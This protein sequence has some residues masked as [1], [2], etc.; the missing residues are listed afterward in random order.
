MAWPED[1][2]RHRE[3]TEALRAWA[4]KIDS[5]P[6]PPG[7]DIDALLARHYASRQEADEPDPV[8]AMRLTATAES[9][10]LA[11]DGEIDLS[12]SR[13][14]RRRLAE[15]VGLAP[16]VLVLDLTGAAHCSA[17]GLAVLLEAT[18]DAREAGV[19]FAIVGCAPVVRR[20]VD[21]LGLDAAL[22]IHATTAEAVEWLELLER[23]T[24]PR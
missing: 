10:V 4:R 16:R 14:L 22:P 7:L 12:G 15:E 20:A 8:M 18:G 6:Y 13:R 5:V 1:D 3:V 2:A 19:L 9:T 21:A 17:R 23:L 11:V 24:A